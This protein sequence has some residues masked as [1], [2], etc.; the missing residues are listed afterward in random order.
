MA[1]FQKDQMTDAERGMAIMM[2]QPV[3]RVPFMLF[4]MGF[5][6]KSVGY[7]IFDVYDDMQKA[8]DAGFK[9]ADIY[10]AMGGI[11]AGYPAIGPWELGGE[12]QWPKG[13]F[14]QCPN[15]EPAVTIEEDA[16]K[17]KLPDPEEMKTLG[18]VPRWLQICQIAKNLG[19]PATLGAYGVWTTAGNIVGVSNLTKW[20]IKKPDL[21]RH[22]LTFSKDF[23]LMWMK[24]L[25]DMERKLKVIGRVF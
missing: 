4:A 2:G 3:D 17:L 12:M 21:V 23:L 6:A 11:M 15:A 16:W 1:L 14:S 10:G 18:Y 19:L 7:S 5:N 25:V 22:L 13:D 8:I 20:T 24:L 9:A